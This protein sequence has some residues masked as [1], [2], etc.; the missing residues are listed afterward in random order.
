MNDT[1]T[2]PARRIGDVIAAMLKEGQIPGLRTPEKRAS[3]ARRIDRETRTK[4]NRQ[5]CFD[6]NPKT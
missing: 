3:V 5:A 4:R 6:F 2:K 1:H